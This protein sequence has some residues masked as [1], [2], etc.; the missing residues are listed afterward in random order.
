M[1]EQHLPT[2]IHHPLDSHSPTIQRGTGQRPIPICHTTGLEASNAEL[3]DMLFYY[4][5]P[6]QTL[7]ITYLCI[8]KYVGKGHRRWAVKG[9]EQKQDGCPN[10]YLIMQGW[11]WANKM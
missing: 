1:L 3:T 2:F 5:N 4:K 9:T 6:A 7:Y 10:R 8:N 11:A